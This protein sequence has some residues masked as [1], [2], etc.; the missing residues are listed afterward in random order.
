M[1]KIFRTNLYK[2]DLGK[3]YLYSLS[4]FGEQ[5]ANETLNQIKE[6]E[7]NALND[8]NF[9]TINEKYHSKIFRY[10]TTKNK[11]TVFF[12]HLIDGVVMITVGYCGREWKFILK[13]I[14]DEILNKTI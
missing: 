9:G 13:K 8:K 10:K 3:V 7:Q 1:G 14:E 6:V 11:Q 5:V 4:C 12:H 2:T